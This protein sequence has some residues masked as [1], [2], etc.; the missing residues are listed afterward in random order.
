MA[1][2]FSVFGHLSSAEPAAINAQGIV[3]GR[4]AI[5]VRVGS[6]A[7]QLFAWSAA[8]DKFVTSVGTTSNASPVDID[9]SGFAVGYVR[10][11]TGVDVGYHWDLGTNANGAIPGTVT[12]LQALAGH[13]T[14]VLDQMAGSEIWGPTGVVRVGPDPAHLHVVRISANGRNVGNVT[15]RAT[16]LRTAWTSFGTGPATMLTP[17]SG[18]VETWAVDVNDCGTILGGGRMTNGQTRALVWSHTTVC[19]PS[20]PVGAP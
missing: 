16:G 17:P 9:D 14:L 15:D 13:R 5:P 10:S 4:L 20:K 8:Q 1:A 11:L 18:F 6:Y 19:D 7:W 3:V 12:V 2:P